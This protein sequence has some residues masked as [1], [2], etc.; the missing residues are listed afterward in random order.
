MTKEKCFYDYEHKCDC[1]EDDKCGCTYPNNMKHNVTCEPE[2]PSMADF[3]HMP[4]EISL[5]KGVK[6]EPPDFHWN[7]EPQSFDA[8]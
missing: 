7:E 6:L 1:L 8:D 4:H 2:Q 5:K 3:E